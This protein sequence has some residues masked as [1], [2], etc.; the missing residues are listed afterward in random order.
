VTD[1][2]VRFDLRTDHAVDVHPVPDDLA[3]FEEPQRRVVG[4]VP[5]RDVPEFLKRLE[6]VVDGT[7]C[8]IEVVHEFWKRCAIEP[9]QCLDYLERR[10]RG[11]DLHPA[12]H[13]LM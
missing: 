7:F 8:H 9:H 10:F 3:E 4:A 1:S 2:G 6:V 5:S 12:A 13:C 11:F